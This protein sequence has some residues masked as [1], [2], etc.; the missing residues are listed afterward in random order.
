M[1]KRGMYMYRGKKKQ[2]EKRGICI[3]EKLLKK[4]KCQINIEVV[5]NS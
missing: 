4:K 2:M 1:E 5:L 3:G